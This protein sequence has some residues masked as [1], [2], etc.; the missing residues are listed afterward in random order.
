MAEAARMTIATVKCKLRRRLKVVEAEIR[1]CYSDLIIHIDAGQVIAVD[2]F[3][4][5]RTSY[6]ISLSDRE[7][8]SRQFAVLCSST[9]TT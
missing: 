8:L 4:G 7:N 2:R 6:Q 3:S 5:V 1:H 9:S